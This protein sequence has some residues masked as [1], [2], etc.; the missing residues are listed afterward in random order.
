MELDCCSVRQIK[1][2]FETDIRYMT[3]SSFIKNE[4]RGRIVEPQEPNECPLSAGLLIT[5]IRYTYASSD[6]MISSVRLR[7]LFKRHARSIWPAA[8]NAPAAPSCLAIAEAISSIR[9]LQVRS[10]SGK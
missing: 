6:N 9:P 7:G 5:G 8:F 1:K 10:I 2:L 4:L 3:I